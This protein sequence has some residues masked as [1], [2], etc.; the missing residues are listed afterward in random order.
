MSTAASRRRSLEAHNA[1]V[2]QPSSR[3]G[4]LGE[5]LFAHGAREAEQG[6]VPG[7]VADGEFLSSQ[8]YSQRA[9]WLRAGVLGANDG[10]V[11][12]ASLMMG[13]GGGTEDLKTLVLSGVAGLVGGALSMAA[14]EYISVYSQKDSQD[15]DIA[16]ERAAQEHG[17]QMR[18]YE[19]NELAGIYEERGLPK[20][21]AKEVAK[22]L[23]KN[24]VIQAH[25]R[26]E[27]GI[28]TEDLANPWLACIT[29]AISFSI[30]A[31]IPLL[32]SSFI[33]D[34]V[35]RLIVVLVAST[36]AL[37]VFGTVGAVLG[38]ASA[39]RG[40]VRVVIGGV[41]AMV[42]TYGVGRLFGV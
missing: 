11:S 23:T 21:L 36:I 16:K 1:P 28:D 10:L 31:A 40:A 9:Q 13:V 6:G 20:D 4:S 26:D 27:L 3:E 39:L 17:P 25:A 22:H 15:A 32:S 35:I 34:H 33:E 29:S 30:G 12:V 5:P 38:G 42:V 7:V 41:L 18:L 2:S 8:H 37:A 14:G 19:L 24:D